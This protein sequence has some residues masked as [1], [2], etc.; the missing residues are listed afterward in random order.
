MK[1]FGQRLRQ[2]RNAAGLTQDDLAAVCKNKEGDGLTRSA[3][4]NWEKDKDKPSFDNLVATIRRLGKHGD[5]NYLLGFS[6]DQGNIVDRTAIDE[7]HLTDCIQLVEETLPPK[8]FPILAE[9]RAFLIR[10]LYERIPATGPLPR[11][12]IVKLA[13]P[14]A[15][16]RTGMGKRHGKRI[17]RGA[18]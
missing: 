6:D 16:I 2:A 9:K 10:T 14:S 1:T 11:A 5:A 7:A 4:S 3:V 15:R 18:A 8:R 13:G 12:E 17:K